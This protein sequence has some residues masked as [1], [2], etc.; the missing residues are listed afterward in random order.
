MKYLSVNIYGGRQGSSS[1]RMKLCCLV[2]WS[3]YSAWP[4]LV[5]LIHEYVYVVKWTEN[6]LYATF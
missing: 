2:Y 1:W 4:L 3:C 5:Y 6:L